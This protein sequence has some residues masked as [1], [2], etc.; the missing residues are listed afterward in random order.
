VNH[1][2]DED[3]VWED[4]CLEIFLD[5]PSPNKSIYNYRH[6]IVNAEGY[7]FDEIGNKGAGSWNGN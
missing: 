2:K 4:S 1:R 6:Y 5:N 3:V 7:K